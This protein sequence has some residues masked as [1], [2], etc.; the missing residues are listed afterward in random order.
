[1]KLLR[2]PL[3]YTLVVSIVLTPVAAQQR[4]RSPEKTPAKPA[5][6][7]TPVPT[8]TPTFENLLAAD[9]FKVYVEVR[10]VGQLIKSSATTD[11]LEPIL[12]LG[13]P[14]KDFVEFIEWLKSHAEQLT[15]SRMLL[16]AWANRPDSPQFV[17]AIEFSSPE[18]AA[19][20]EKP[21]NSVLPTMFP[22]VPQ[23]SPEAEKKTEPPQPAADQKAA[24]DQKPA[25]EQKPVADQKPVDQKP[26]D[27]KPAATL[28]GYS[29]QRAGSL[30]LVSQTALDLKKLRRAGSKPLAEDPNFRVAYNRFAS[31]P[32]FLFVD[33]KAIQKERDE[34]EKRW[35]EERKK[36]ADASKERKEKEA[37]EE[38][39]EEDPESMESKTTVTGTFEPRPTLTA[40]TQPPAENDEPK[41]PSQAQLTSAALSAVSSSLFSTI[42]EMPD[43]LGVGFSPDSDSFDFRALMIDAAGKSSDPIPFFSWIKFGSPIAPR[44]STVIPADSELVLTMSLDLQQLYARMSAPSPLLLT[45][46]TDGAA[47]S[48]EPSSGI[49]SLEKV[50]KIKIKDDLLPLLGSEVAVSLPLATFNPLAAPSAAPTPQPKEGEKEESSANPHKP[51]VVISLRDKEAM[52][53]LLPKLIEAYVGQAAASMG[54]TEKREDTELVSYVNMFAYAFIGDFLVLSTDVATTRHVVDSYL[55]GATLAGDVQF[56]NSTRWQPHAVQGQ[57]YVSSAFVESYKAWANNPN[58]RITDEARAFLTHLTTTPQAITYSLTN[59]GLGTLHELHLPKNAVLLAVTAAAASGN[60]PPTAINERATISTLWTIANAER[61]YKE[62]NNT[63]YAS[64]EELVAA[65]VLSKEALE[66]V[67]YKL[68]FMITADGYTVSA[69]PVEYGKTGKLSFFL[70]QTGVVR[71]ADHAGGPAGESDPPAAY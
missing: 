35:E 59:D 67:N 42:P 47:I 2:L 28:P 17:A 37:A 40:V 38:E 14:P 7:P 68:D 31:E 34:R 32:L 46:D 58:A 10:N 49:T 36:A 33:F 53:K 39:E 63:G 19:K 57:V 5:A 25:A 20:F 43:A 29:L 66:N 6:A 61:E 52:R 26:T 11:I 4:R 71:G 15:T 30:L 21:L 41:E 54:Q 48:V 12:K 23:S 70:N 8:P 45:G 64:L 22:P 50:L 65:E 27:Q 13:G 69:V 3:L 60:P 24:V 1:M 62:K 9:D 55:K 16:A 44:S 56:R 18:E 51:F